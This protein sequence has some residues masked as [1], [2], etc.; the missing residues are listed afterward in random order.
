[1]TMTSNSTYYFLWMIFFFQVIFIRPVFGQA[2]TIET[3]TFFQERQPYVEVHLRIF[4][5]QLAYRKTQRGMVAKTNVSMD[6]LSGDSLV[7]HIKYN[8]LSPSL[9][10]PKDIID[11]K[12]FA[13]HPGKYL[14]TVSLHFANKKN[15]GE[16]KMEKE[17][18]IPTFKDAGGCSDLILLSAISKTEDEHNPI[19]KNGLLIEPLIFG[20]V[21]ANRRSLTGYMEIY[22]QDFHAKTLKYS[23]VKNKKTIHTKS[24]RLKNRPVIPQLMTISI[25]ELKAGYY[26][27][28]VELMDDQSKVIGSRSARFY[29][30]APAKDAQWWLE[31]TDGFDLG[32]FKDVQSDA[33]DYALKSLYPIIDQEKRGLLKIVI[34]SGNDEKKIA[35]LNDFWSHKYPDSP[36]ANYEKYMEIV[37]KIDKK[38]NSNVG[39]GFETDRG[40]IFLKYGNPNKVLTIDTEVDAPP[41]EIWYYHYLPD[42]RQTDVRFLFYNPS[43]AHNDF[44]L[45]HSTCL[46]EVSNPAWEVELYR[47]AANSQQ[48]NT[49]DATSVKKGWNRKA[50]QY[51]EDY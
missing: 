7:N 44:H 51:F 25:E 38:F 10:S 23:V 50:R 35:F 11:V 9:K 41:Y 3:Y 46:G 20:V 48:G 1:M 27:F 19:A 24:H 18:D 31:A 12:R 13:L 28:L 33:L 26:L 15:G 22:P 21:P 8:L 30:A 14:L 39:Y 45:L 16:L 42:T 32:V 6:I 47:D 4:G 49:I 2:A 29:K 36:L 43:L 37:R 5:D 34:E 17:I 40:Y